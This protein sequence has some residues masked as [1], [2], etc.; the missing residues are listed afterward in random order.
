MQDATVEAAALRARVEEL[1][2][3]LGA[4]A[5]DV[6]TAAQ[7]QSAAPPWAQWKRVEDFPRDRLLFVSFSNGHYAE[8]MMNWVQTLRVLE[9][10]PTDGL[11]RLT[12]VLTTA[13]EVAY[14]H[15]RQA[16]VASEQTQ[17]AA[18]ITCVMSCPCYQ[19]ATSCVQVPHMV[20]A[21]DQGATDVCIKN[22]VVT[23]PADEQMETS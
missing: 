4:A 2:Q 17:P 19:T 1:Q 9:V 22:G 23:M 10:T 7:A 5:Q 13:Q 16:R 18:G 21:F 8:L 20:V 3:R 11:A 14:I 6:G 15:A 12:A